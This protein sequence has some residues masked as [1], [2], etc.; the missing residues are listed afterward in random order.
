MKVDYYLSGLFQY[1]LGI[2]M[3]MLELYSQRMQD[4]SLSMKVRSV[5]VG[6]RSENQ[7][8]SR[9]MIVT[10]K[11]SLNIKAAAMQGDF[12]KC[13]PEDIEG[14]IKALIGRTPPTPK[15]YF[16]QLTSNEK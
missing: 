2:K 8:D 7:V 4:G 16:S 1:H 15:E 6:M 11:E 14:K 10:S 5:H 9:E 13:N 3:E 12:Q